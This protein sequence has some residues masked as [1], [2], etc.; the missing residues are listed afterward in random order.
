MIYCYYL[1]YKT[2]L[3]VRKE[4]YSDKLEKTLNL[5]KFNQGFNDILDD[6]K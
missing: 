2:Y 6:E 3:D 5:V 1:I 4:I